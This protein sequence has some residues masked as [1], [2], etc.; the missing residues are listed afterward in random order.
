MSDRQASGTAGDPAMENVRSVIKKL[1][2]ATHRGRLMRREAQSNVLELSKEL[3]E[4]NMNLQAVFM[5]LSEIDT[6]VA[7]AESRK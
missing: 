7:K 2:D 1:G 6:L 3:N 5:Q 4:V